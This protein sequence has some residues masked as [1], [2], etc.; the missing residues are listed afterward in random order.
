MEKN[1][2]EYG[3]EIVRGIW[4]GK[5]ADEFGKEYCTNEGLKKDAMVIR[6]EF[7]DGT[8]IRFGEDRWRAMVVKK[9]EPEKPET[10]EEPK[11]TERD[12]EPIWQQVEEKA[13]EKIEKIMV[14][15]GNRDKNTMD[16]ATEEYNRF[17]SELS[18]I[19][20]MEE[21]ELDDRFTS[22]WW[23]RQSK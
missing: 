4:L 13:V 1:K 16:R 10:A 23:S 22:L 17:L 9:E 19:L 2:M 20:G 14:A 8:K 12:L 21:K 6:I 18:E 11:T 15:I 3:M 5:N 7:R